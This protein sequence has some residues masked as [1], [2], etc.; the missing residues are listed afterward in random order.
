MFLARESDWRE[1]AK[2][3]P[4]ADVLSAPAGEYLH[5][6]GVHNSMGDNGERMLWIAPIVVCVLKGTNLYLHF[7]RGQPFVQ[8]LYEGEST[9][10]VIHKT[11]VRAFEFY[12]VDKGERICRF[13]T[14][15]P[16]PDKKLMRELLERYAQQHWGYVT[17]RTVVDD[18][19][20]H[21]FYV[22]LN[23][24]GKKDV[25]EPFFVDVIHYRENTA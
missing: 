4:I 7:S 14:I 23:E 20:D 15:D 21:D 19:P 8:P 10:K 18:D 25:F 9:I 3:V 12:S 24:Q 2:A 22:R 6:E 1:Q 17:P 11:A 13:E 5:V 16:S